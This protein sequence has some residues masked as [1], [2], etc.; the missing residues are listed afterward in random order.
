VA[1]T[2][3]TV[4][5]NI[6]WKGFDPASVTVQDG[7]VVTWTNNGNAPHQVVADDGSFKSDVLKPGDTFS[8]AF[9]S[10]GAFSYHGGWNPALRGSVNVQPPVP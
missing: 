6:T 9:S 5:V 7:D 1:T 2:P 10:P 3:N 8:Y 4:K